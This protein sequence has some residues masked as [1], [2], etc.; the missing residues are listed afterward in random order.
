MP[1]RLVTA[2]AAAAH[3]GVSLDTLRAW[4]RAGVIPVFRDPD[5]GRCRY[6]IPA[7]DRWLADNCPP[8]AS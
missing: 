1:G 6:S 3:I 5:S 7:L 4:T 8:V 2:K